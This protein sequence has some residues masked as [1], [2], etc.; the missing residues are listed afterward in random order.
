[1][2]LP[3]TLRAV[4]AAF[5]LL[6]PACAFGQ[7]NYQPAKVTT[8]AGDTLRGYI[9]DRGWD[10]NPRVV[11]F[12][13]DL[14][15]SEQLF[16]P[17]DIKGFSVSN[18]RYAG[19]KVN[20]EVSSQDLDKL[21]PTPTPS[22]Q[23]D[24]AFLRALVSGAKSLY[25]YK[26]V[27]TSIYFYI[28]Q[29]NSFDLLV[30]KRYKRPGEGPVEVKNNNT[31]QT[32]LELY[33]PD[34]P[35]TTR[36]LKAT[37]Y[38]ASSLQHVFADYYACTSR[39]VTFPLRRKNRNQLGILAGI[40][41]AT[42]VFSDPTN[43]AYPTFDSYTHTGPTG[44]LYYYVPLPGTLGHFSV[45]NDVIFTS[46]KGSGSRKNVVSTS[47]YST[48]TFSLELAYLK[49]NTLLRFTQPVGAGTIFINAGISNAYA[50]QLKS[51]KSV[52]QQFYSTERTTTSELFPNPRR[53]EQG[54]VAGVGASFKK[55]SAEARY[56]TSNGFLVYYDLG[57]AVGR[58][59]LLVG[60]RFR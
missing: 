52:R 11:S 43:P 9:N 38:S 10:Q 56:E 58:Y 24:T 42:L 2:K 6:L 57:S 41:R 12:K 18:E 54:L 3:S 50:M 5:L 1:M 26:K 7:Q 16:H 28:Q 59:S 14:Q 21:S 8:L 32:Q 47:E 22:L 35:T 31:F 45:N 44:G 60:Y 20:I 46:F 29:G 33:L 34:C 19:A 23:A 36:R 53:Y 37:R 55:L 40:S 27:N 4:L 15:A 49:L 17:L 30:Y 48:T 13:T 51:E 25:Q 39:P